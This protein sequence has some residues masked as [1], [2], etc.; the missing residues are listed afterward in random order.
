MP[1]LYPE[2][3]VRWEGTY[4]CLRGGF[5]GPQGTER[6]SGSWEMFVMRCGG[7]RGQPGTWCVL[8]TRCHHLGG[9]FAGQALLRIY[10]H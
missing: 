6:G 9:M 5:Q 1:A 8:P 4:G 3:Q 7:C 2:E 10:T